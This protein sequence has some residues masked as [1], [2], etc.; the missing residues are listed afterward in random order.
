MASCVHDSYIV[1]T[2]GRL[3]GLAFWLSD[4]VRRVGEGGSVLDPS[5]V[6]QLVG[7]RR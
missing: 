5:V 1:R 7:R 3:L 4:A 6:S 2:P